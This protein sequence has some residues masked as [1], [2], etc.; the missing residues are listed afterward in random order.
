METNG[1][2]KKV[3]SCFMHLL[4]QEGK[5]IIIISSIFFP[6]LRSS[7]HIVETQQQID[8]QNRHSSDV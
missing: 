2:L 8:L 4:E 5:A 3:P 6:G 7:S 1:R